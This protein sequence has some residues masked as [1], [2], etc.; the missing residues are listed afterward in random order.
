MGEEQ[1]W[2]TNPELR[3]EAEAEREKAK[4]G[5]NT[6]E[7][8]GDSG[9][10]DR[11]AAEIARL[12]NLPPL[13]YERERKA[14]AKRLGCLVTV[15]DRLVKSAHSDATPGQGRPLDLT[16]PDAWP[17][18]VDGDKLL[19]ELSVAIRRY[20]VLDLHAADTVALWVVGVHAFDAWTIFPRL[21]A[22]APEKQCG[23]STLL[24][25]IGALVP[26]ALSADSI[27]AAALFRTIE[28][29]RPTLL[30]DEADTYVRNREDLRGVLD[31][32]HR[33]DGGVIRTVGDDHEPR[34]FST[35]APVVLAAIG[36]LPGTVEDRGIKISL[37]RRR[38][39]EPADLLRLDRTD[40]FKRLASMAARWAADHTIKLGMSDPAMPAGIF[41]RPADNWRPL[42]AVADAA[43]G[44]WPERAQQAAT[45]LTFDGADDESSVRVALLT[46]IRN[47]FAAKDTDRLSSEDLVDYLVELDER[48]WP[49]FKAGRPITKTQVARLLKPFGI[50]SGTARFEGRPTAKPTA[51]GYHLKGFE[52]AFMRYLPP[53]E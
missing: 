15:L 21:L 53:A 4:A 13:A 45:K 31:S 25:A 1:I 20:V 47:A 32:G 49:E 52:D 42:L 38:P 2:D 12:A 50:S 35:W 23:K 51:K 9:E 43:G 36:H 30:L 27:T 26:R 14:A 10:G 46:D 41:N 6:G 39:D 7:K 37:R 33:R 44:E 48:P 11:D 28:T 40:E 22:T 29:A 17:E 18:E 3:A 16:K 24:D 34:R 8:N 5:E 19:D